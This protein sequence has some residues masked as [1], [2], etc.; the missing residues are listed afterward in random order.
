MI[1]LLDSRYRLL[2]WGRG[3]LLGR[4]KWI[5]KSLNASGLLRIAEQNGEAPLAY[6][7]ALVAANAVMSSAERSTAPLPLSISMAAGRPI[8]ATAT[9]S[10]SELLEDRHTALLVRPG[11]ARAMAQ[12]IMELREDVAMQRRISDAAPAR[13]IAFF[14]RRGGW[15]TSAR[16][17]SNTPRGG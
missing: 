1:H 14:R 8:I 2:L 16:C 7:E 13:P 17:I 5:A 10:T 4:V 11:S 9:S 3:P 15:K 12:R 6:E